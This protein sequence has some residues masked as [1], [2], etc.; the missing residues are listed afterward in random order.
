MKSES[1]D[2]TDFHLNK[3]IAGELLFCNQSDI[4]NIIKFFSL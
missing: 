3:F 4:K 1:T 2:S